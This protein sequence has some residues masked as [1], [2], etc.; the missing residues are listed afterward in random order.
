MLLIVV[1]HLMFYILANL[2]K[3][4][5]E[6]KIVTATCTQCSLVCIKVKYFVIFIYYKLYSSWLC[7][8]HSYYLSGCAM[9]SFYDCMYCIQ[10][11]TWVSLLLPKEKNVNTFN[12]GNKKW[13]VII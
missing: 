6:E 4:F 8:F 3:T 9:Y 12:N 11:Q 13:Q 5:Y 10:S 7:L 1:T 2:F